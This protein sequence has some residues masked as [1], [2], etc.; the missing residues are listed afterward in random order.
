MVAGKPLLCYSID[1]ALRAETVTRIVLSTDSAEYAA[2]AREH[3]AEAPFLR[4]PEISGD[5]ATDLDAFAHAL[6]WLHEHEQYVPEIC[7]HLRPTYPIRDPHDIDEMVRLLASKEQVDSVRGI[8]PAKQTPFKMWRRDE[9]GLLK[10]VVEDLD[11]PEAYNRPRQELPR[12]Y[13]QNNCI[14]VL[15][16]C[17]V[18][19]KHSMTGDFIL[20]Y[21]MNGYFD[22]DTEEQL[23]SV[24]QVILKTQKQSR[25]PN[26]RTGGNEM[27]YRRLGTTGLKV[28]VLGFGC[29][30]TIGTR[31]DGAEAQRLVWQAFDSGINHFDTANAYGR[32]LAESAL[33]EIVAEMPRDEL[34]LASK[35][36]FPMGDDVNSRGLSRKHILTAVNASLKRLRTDYL[37]VY[38]CHRFD[39]E[40][41]LDETLRT[42][43]MLVQS[44]KV[45]YWGTSQWTPD[46]LRL[47]HQ[48]CAANGWVAPSVEQPQYNLL[49]RHYVES[50]LVPLSSE[51]G[52]G[53]VTWSPLASGVLAGVYN[54]G[55]PA[56]RR[57]A[58][59]RM[60]WL[61]EIMAAKENVALSR[62][63]GDIASQLGSSQAALAISWVAR[64]PA[65]SSVLLGAS[66]A[67]QL[68]DNIS[69]VGLSLPEAVQQ[70]LDGMFRPCPERVMTW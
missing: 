39:E 65:V 1:H 53:L 54:D 61:R 2:I 42:M 13:A 38:Y 30:N 35:V 33:G 19:A 36:Y 12:I 41:P 28:S 59:G 16:G 44:G 25:A 7:V 6:A 56:G 27:E 4:P 70:D 14:D 47:A 64:R 51:L 69:A 46:Q 10:P 20:G 32:G 55:M 60:Q 34:V 50:E 9:G 22:I 52:F 21:E 40:T 15:R 24:E 68:R 5:L 43:T 48:R 29:W 17:T 57:L 63:L 23:R 45:L 58:D 37:D 3:G 11:F 49:H 66:N 8:V 26:T 62:K 31:V 18:T 67:E